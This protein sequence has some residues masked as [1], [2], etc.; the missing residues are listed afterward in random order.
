[1]T[2]VSKCKTDTSVLC[3]R[4]IQTDWSPQGFSRDCIWHSSEN[5][6]QQK[7]DEEVK[8]D[9]GGLSQVHYKCQK[10]GGKILVTVLTAWKNSFPSAYSYSKWT[11]K[12]FWK[13]TNR[14]SPSHLLGQRLS[15]VHQRLPFLVLNWKLSSP[16]G[17]TEL[18]D[19][20][21]PITRGALHPNVKGKVNHLNMWA[22]RILRF[23]CRHFTVLQLY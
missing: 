21:F 2:A 20:T 11:G 12:K 23:L 1:M 10:W 6:F 7:E 15:A 16:F 22:P 19:W 13:K 8:R 9:T 3:M 14:E 5:R 18:S 4:C 17:C